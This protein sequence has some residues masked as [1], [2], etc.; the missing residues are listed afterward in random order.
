VLK[1][2]LPWLDQ[3]D[4]RRPQRLPVVHTVEEVQAVLT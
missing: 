2:E 4:R 3:I 1:Q